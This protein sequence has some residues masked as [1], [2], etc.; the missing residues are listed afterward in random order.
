[1]NGLEAVVMNGGPQNE[2]AVMNGEQPTVANGVA[3]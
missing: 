3:A 2:A 1:M